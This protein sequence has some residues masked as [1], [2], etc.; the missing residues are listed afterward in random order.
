MLMSTVEVLEC[1]ERETYAVDSVW[2][3][4]LSYF[5]SSQTHNFIAPEVHFHA[6]SIGA[7]PIKIARKTAKLLKFLW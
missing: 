1:R 2:G 7:N 5:T 4:L 3:F 6:E